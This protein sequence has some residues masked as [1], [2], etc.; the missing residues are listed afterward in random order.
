MKKSIP[1]L[2]LFIFCLG[3]NDS[4][5][6]IKDSNNTNPKSLTTSN[7][8]FNHKTA[9]SIYKSYRGSARFDKPESAL[10]TLKELE[11]YYFG[12][13]DSCRLA[14]VY[15][16]KSKCYDMMGYLDSSLA[17]GQRALLLYKPQCDSLTLM[18]INLNLTSTY[19]SLK[20]NDKVIEIVDKSLAHWNDNWRKNKIKNAM[21]TNKAIALVYNG[22][23]N[24]GMETFKELLQYARKEDDQLS[25]MD[26][27]NNLAAL[28]GMLYEQKGIRRYLDSSEYYVTQALS[29][30]KRLDKKHEMVMHLMNLASIARDNGKFI[31]SLTYL[32]SA[33]VYANAGHYLD[34]ATSIT[35]IRSQALQGI[36]NLDSALNT[37]NYHIL[38][39]D[40]LL[41]TEKM[42]AISE[43]REKYESEKK[44]RQI[45]EL[46]V[47]GLNADLR[48]EQ[49]TK[50]RNVFLF[51]GIF[52]LLIAGGLWSR[53]RFTKK[54]KAAIQIE[55]DISEELL[56]N[57][58]P[59]EVAKEL[60]EKGAAD[61]Q[62]IEQVTVIFTDFKG[63][64]AMS[65]QLSPK[66]LVAD[67]HACFS[68][69]DKV[70]EQHGIEKIKTIGDAYM[71][72]GGLPTPNQTHPTDVVKA[73]LEMAE[74]VKREK[75]DK[76]A[77]NKPFFEV[78][79]GVHT[80]PVVAGIVGVKKF[81]YDIWGDT[82]N[83]AN[84]MESSGQEGKVNISHTTYELLKDDSL[85]TFES[86]G[87]IEAK[88]KGEIEMYFVS[89]A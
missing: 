33:I 68:E 59:E 20:E 36:G 31:S 45:K 6:K 37:L 21:Y 23:A 26:A 85:F 46:E 67:L 62:L 24:L 70:C 65:E 4:H 88:G 58:L 18:L 35:F 57:I 22:Q 48:E 5:K 7:T 30:S 40:S 14:Y 89:K 19:L 87:K 29:I 47:A 52:I 43:M 51:I 41:S 75:A 27:S 39:K 8:K 1:F 72:A 28:F 12:Q 71:A 15:T 17:F 50:N 16:W 78:R 49:L 3:C 77:A 42:R 13:K 60:K 56:L 53:L 44:E 81:Q 73:A 83:T 79:I 66:E 84:R 76:I 32:D 74:V 34:L 25:V 10:L 9:D 69:F 63:F 2:L 11:N 86:R 61:A 55:K 38:L 80:G 64:T 82:V 54:A